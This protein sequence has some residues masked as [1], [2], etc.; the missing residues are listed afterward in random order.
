ML[1]EVEQ[2][3]VF[4]FS[5]PSTQGVLQFVI[6]QPNSFYM[7]VVLACQSLFPVH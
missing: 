7:Q 4:S 1:L 2:L 6:P 3:D 5:S